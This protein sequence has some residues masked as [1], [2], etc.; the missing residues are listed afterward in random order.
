MR[1]QSFVSVDGDETFSDVALV[2]LV[3]AGLLSPVLFSLDMA[4]L[5]DSEG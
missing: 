4:F 5:R 2:V 3:S 1:G